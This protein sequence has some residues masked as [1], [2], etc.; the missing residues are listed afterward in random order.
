MVITGS[1]AQTMIESFEYTDD[2][3]LLAS[4]TPGSGNTLLSLSNS[5]SS[6]ASGTKSMRVEFNF[7]SSEWATEVVDGVPLPAPISIDPA[8]Y[9]SFRLRGD[10]AFATSDFHDIYLYAWDA[11]GN[12]GRWG[13]STPSTDDWQVFNFLASTV[14]KPW[15]STALP[16][17]S[18][19]VR[20]AFYQYGSAG[21]LPPYTAVIYLDEVAIRDQP[22][23][24]PIEF[25]SPSAPREI[26]ENF[27]GYADDAALTAFYTIVNSPS[28]TTLT[29]PS[30]TSPAPQGSKALKMAIDFSNGQYPWGSLRS[31]FVAPFSF[32]TNAVASV[33]VKGD[34]SLAAIADGG[35][36]FW[37]C[38]YDRAGNRIIHMAGTPPVISSDWT[39]VQATLADFTDA[40]K[41]DIGNLVR[42]EVLVEGWTGVPE[43]AAASGTFY[44]DDIRITVPTTPPALSIVR[45]GTTLALKLEQ[46]TPGKSYQLRTS[47]DLT[48]WTTATVINASSPSTT[49]TIP[50]GQTKGFYQLVQ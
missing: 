9:V 36:T 32:P 43:Q 41:V 12:F 37:L 14:A 8:K 25:P 29:T 49:W 7:G 47:I 27:E 22:L 5:V 3:E 33:R 42:W 50:S 39:N 11:D 38:F 28:T 4:W 31:G 35:T 19:I 34:P 16:D 44:I 30:L 6:H 40:S 48:Q 18:R 26:I 13:V 23:V 17:L 46:L 20:F 1:Q 24:E 10:S 2:G 21:V 45:D 15:N